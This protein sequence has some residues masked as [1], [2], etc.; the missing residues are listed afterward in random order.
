MKSAAYLKS[1][2][3]FVGHVQGFVSISHEILAIVLRDY[4]E[5]ESIPIT[6]LSVGK[7]EGE[8][9]ESGYTGLAGP[10]NAEPNP[11]AD[12]PDGSKAK[13]KKGRT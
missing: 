4:V 6:R 1:T 7:Q 2:K 10:A 12:G 13:G 8:K 5:I 11:G 9:H 3:E